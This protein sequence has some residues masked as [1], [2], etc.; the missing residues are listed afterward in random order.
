MPGTRR[1]NG[2]KRS[3]RKSDDDFF[4]YHGEGTNHPADAPRSGQR[5][6][7]LFDEFRSR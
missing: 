5:D 4:Q 1:A 3:L 2:P 6:G 7:L